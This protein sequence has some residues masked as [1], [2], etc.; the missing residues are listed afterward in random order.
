MP[1]R[2]EPFQ[3]WEQSGRDPERYRELMLEHGHILPV[4]PCPTCG[5]R[6]R[7]RHTAAGAIVPVDPFGHDERADG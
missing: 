3:L 1:D 2:P 4:E 5:E 7:H 6:F